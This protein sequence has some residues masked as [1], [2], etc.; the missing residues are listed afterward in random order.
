MFKRYGDEAFENRM[1]NVWV[2]VRDMEPSL[3]PYGGGI[4]GVFWLF[5]M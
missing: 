3:L 5:W 4:Q 1:S 2:K